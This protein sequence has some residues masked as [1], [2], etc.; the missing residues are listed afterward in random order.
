MTTASQWSARALMGRRSATLGPYSP[1]FYAEPLQIESAHDVWMKGFDG[2]EYLDAY[3]NVPHVGHCN[4]AVIRAMTEQAAR[5]N[6]N[7]RYLSTPIVEYAEILLATFGAHLDKVFFT[8]SGSEANELALRIAR[9]H[10]SRSG[11]LVSDFS[12]HG[13]TTSLAVATTGIGVAEPLGDHVRA[14]HI[15]DLDHDTR[16]EHVVLQSALAEASGAI[17]SLQLSGHGVS[18]LL[19]DPLFSTEGL[20]RLPHG[21]VEALVSLVKAA[22]GL[23]IADEVQSGFGRTGSHMWGHEMFEFAPDIVVLGKPMGNGH[24]LG[25][26]VTTTELLEDFGSRNTYFN[27][28]AGNPV[29]AAVGQAVLAEMGHRELQDNARVV[30][31]R[32]REILEKLSSGRPLI[33]AVKGMGLF[34]GLEIVDEEGRPDASRTKWLVED[35]RRRG[36]LIS[37]IGASDNVL[38]IRP[39]LVFGEDHLNTLTARLADSLDVLENA[40]SARSTHLAPH[41][42]TGDVQAQNSLARGVAE[43]TALTQAGSSVIGSKTSV[44]RYEPKQHGMTTQLFINGVWSDA[45]ETFDDLNPA[46]GEVL[47]KVANGSAEDIG[48]AVGAARTVLDGEWSSTPGAARAALLL[49]LA[50]LIERDADHLARMEALDIGKPVGQPAMLDVPNAVATF[51]HFAGWADKIQGSTIPTPGYMGV[52]P[53]HSYTVREPVGVIGAIV[54]WNTPLM[55][56]AWKLAPALAAGNTLVVKPAEDAPLSILHLGKLIEEAGFPAG[57]VNIV[58]GLGSVAG[59]ALVAHPGVDKISFT[60]SPEVGRQIQKSAADTFKRVTLELGGK[61]PQIVME[62]ANVEAAINGVAMGL[63]FNQ[64]EVCAAGTRILVHRSHYDT[65]VEALG[66]A[67][68]A[69][70]LGDPFAETTTLG[71]LVNAKQQQRVLDYIEKGKS[72]GARLVAGGGRHEG[73]GFFVQ[74][75]IFA[76]VDNDST[77]A[78]EEIFGPVGAVI[79][80]DTPE[81]AV[82]I[83]N[84]TT[85]GLAATIWTQNV[86]LAHTLASRVRAGAVWVNGWAAIDPALPWGGMKAS[87]IG[88]ELGWS[89]ILANTEEKVITIVL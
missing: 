30:G 42:L 5:L 77:I 4:P 12:Y 7:T 46:T 2:V 83:A 35:M 11:V 49:K 21:Y 53:T 80:F 3:N 89:G 66:Q 23:V 31:D 58:P 41:G 22:G 37:K 44:G 74:P 56:A 59:A 79:P 29:S 64:G 78:R 71:A 88:R 10:T 60:G 68:N 25:A 75:T 45:A 14:L 84:A 20:L 47:V 57:V 40:T 76:D 13:N 70:V 6:I 38:K 34:I 82:A 15:P 52:A 55:I 86:S 39:P 67:A 28:F 9:Q 1:M 87:G 63:F 17:N 50:D 19:F 85:Y 43:T 65:V 69:Q 32:A 24:P 26:A 61:S 8:N 48:R 73:R 16:P 33:K 18:T 27:T 81:E 51:R 54:P 36:V 62:D 72:E